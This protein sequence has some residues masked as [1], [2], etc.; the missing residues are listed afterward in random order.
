[1]PLDGVYSGWLFADGERF[2]AALSVGINETI[3]A[4]PR[5]IEAH[6]LDRKD[7]DLYD[8]TVTLE[9]VSFLRPAAKFDG[10]ETLIKA[11]GDDC[12]RIREILAADAADAADS[13]AT[14]AS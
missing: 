10:I 13:G 11:I 4:V 6:V 14:P 5:L 12:D 7:L 3:Q 8:K 2:P 9:Y 1:L